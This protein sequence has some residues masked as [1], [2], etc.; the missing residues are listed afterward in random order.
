MTS[1]QRIAGI[2]LG[3]TKIVCGIATGA[4]SVLERT[5]IPTRVPGETLVD[6]Q[7]WL[8]PRLGDTIGVGIASFGPVYV[9]PASPRYGHIGASP[10]TAWRDFD[11][12]HAIREWTELRQFILNYDIG[13]VLEQGG[14]AVYPLRRRTDP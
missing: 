13:N 9:D 1:D 6:I 2:E 4:G 10:K 11:L 14:L 3:G 12:L 5:S 7:N 8:E